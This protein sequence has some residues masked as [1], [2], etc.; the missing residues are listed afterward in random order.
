MQPLGFPLGSRGGSRQSVPFSELLPLFQLRAVLPFG[1]EVIH[2]MVDFH[3]HILPGVDDGSK[4]VEESLQMLH[5]EQQQGVDAV[6]LTPH[7]YADQTNPERFLEKREEAWQR[8]SAALEPGMPRFLMGA[9]VYYFDGM[10]NVAQ[11]PRLCI[12]DTG[13]LLLEMP[14]QPWDDRVIDTV[15]DINSRSDMQVVLAHIERYFHLCRKKEYW[16]QLREGGVLMQ[17]NCGFFQGFFNRKKAVKMFSQDEF[18]LIGSDAHN[19]TSRK[20]NWELVPPEIAEAA[21]SF[22]RELLGL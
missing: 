3:C 2:T 20:P 15:L 5:L 12:G 7:F 14:F 10:E 21:G 9:E 22:A 11:L 4:S 19:L 8:L 17:V 18:Q 1:K 6:I 13:V 16:Q